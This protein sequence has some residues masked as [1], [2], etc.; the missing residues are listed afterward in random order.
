VGALGQRTASP[1][2]AYSFVIATDSESRRKEQ[3]LE[4][5]SKQEVK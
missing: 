5:K 2:E 4:E 1:L 3:E